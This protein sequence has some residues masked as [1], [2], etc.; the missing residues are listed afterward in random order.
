MGDDRARNPFSCAPGKLRPN[1]RVADQIVAAFAHERA[2]Q[3][4]AI[5]NIN[6]DAFQCRAAT[7]DEQ[8]V[9]SVKNAG[10]ACIDAES[11]CRREDRVLD[12]ERFKGDS[13]NFCGRA[14]FDKVSIFDLT[15]FQRSPG[16]LR[17]EHRAGR[18]IFQTPR[19]VGVS[20][21]ENNR[22]GSESFEFAE[23]I[24]SAIDHHFG[25]AI[26]DEKRTMH[27]MASGS[28]FDFAAGAQE[29]D[30]HFK[31]IAAVAIENQRRNSGSC[32]TVG[33]RNFIVKID[34]PEVT[35]PDETSRSR[36]PRIKHVS[37]GRLEVEGKSEPYKD[38]KLFPG[39]SRE[40]NWRETGTGHV[41]GIQIADVQ[42]L[43]DHGAKVLVLSRGMQQCL[44]VPPETLDFLKERQIEAH[45]LP[46]TEAVD[47]YNKFAENQAVGGL[48]HTTC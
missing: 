40:W 18:A 1:R 27:P 47:L 39:G 17:R 33:R 5:A 26:R 16:S 14:F 48:F 4:R 10:P 22:V 12:R 19:M 46:T 36:S 32:A 41:P 15:V 3:S 31:T 7:V 9:R 34:N 45:V 35:R 42:E 24:E 6:L 28:G 20:V 11:D 13:A 2:G 29:D 37:W 30:F 23:P 44:E 38:A 21:A 8:Q 25:A 43:L